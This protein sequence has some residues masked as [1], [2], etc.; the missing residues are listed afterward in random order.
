MQS[1]VKLLMN[2][3]YG[4]QIRKDI[5]E[6]FACKSE[7][8]MMS[9]YDERA[10][11]FWRISHGNY[12]VEMTDDAGLEDEVKKLNI[13]PLHLGAFVLSNSKRIMNHLIHAIN[14]FYTND[15]YYT[16][17]DSL[18]IENKHWHNID[19]A[20]LVGKNLLQGKNDYKDGG[21]FYGLF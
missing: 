21:I 12:I 11:D 15:V 17:T 18:C 3:L 19:K 5:G 9:E 4:E 14:G 7:V 16:D 1:L 2:S 6:S 8:W 20:G 13:M 10:K